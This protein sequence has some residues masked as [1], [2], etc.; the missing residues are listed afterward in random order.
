MP[1]TTYQISALRRLALILPFFAGM[2]SVLIAQEWPGPAP[3]LNFAP[4]PEYA[5]SV[6]MFQG[7]PTIERAANGRL[8]AAWY[9]GG[10]GEDRYNYIMVAT[11]G[12]DGK[13]WSPLKMVIDPDGNGPSRAFDPCLW[14]DPSGRLWLFWAHRNGPN[15]KPIPLWATVTEDSGNENPKWS[16]PRPVAQGIMMNRPLVTSSG[17]WLLPVA[18]WK[19]EGSSGVVRSTDQGKTF[20]LIG[21]ATIPDE[22]Q[23]NC[24]EH[25][26]VQRGDGSLLMWVRATYGIGQSISTDGG[27]TWPDFE[28]SPV[29]HV[30]ARFFIR[31]LASGKLLLVKHGPLDERVGRSKM[32]AFLSDDDAKTWRGGLM[33]DE[34]TLVSYPDGV[35]SPDGTIYIIYDRERLRD[36][37]ILMATFKEEDILAG[38]CVSSAARLQVLVNQATGVAPP[39][40]KRPVEKK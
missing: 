18:N 29:E 28:K 25:M 19:R 39:K 14:H 5:D 10:T 34:R 3:K 11:S 7:I 16:E 22:S 4:G 21:K 17:A 30:A 37:Q 33:L 31:R 13:S 20:Q 23:R 35:Q 27:K 9:G 36:K 12:D 38:K 2:S 8:W 6:R 32:M 26:L 15:D 1:T 40:E 24:D